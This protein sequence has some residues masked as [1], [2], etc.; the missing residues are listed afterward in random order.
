MQPLPGANR[1]IILPMCFT[2]LQ[3]IDISFTRELLDTRDSAIKIIQPDG[4]RDDLRNG[5][6][7]E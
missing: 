1:A 3:W 5:F 2:R 4:D 7:S 6:S